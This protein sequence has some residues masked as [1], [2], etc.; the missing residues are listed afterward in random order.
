L[1]IWLAATIRS[2]DALSE[3]GV[4]ALAQLRGKRRVVRCAGSVGSSNVAFRGIKPDSGLARPFDGASSELPV[5]LASES[6]AST[7]LRRGVGSLV[8]RQ[9]DARW[10]HGFLGHSKITTTE[11][12]GTPKRS[13]RTSTD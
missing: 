6:C 12:T 3:R 8:A 10:I 1:P 11:A 5:P 9:A 4:A 7:P 2:S 13:L